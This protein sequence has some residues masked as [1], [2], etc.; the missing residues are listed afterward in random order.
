MTDHFKMTSVAELHQYSSIEYMVGVDVCS[1]RV[2]KIQLFHT[3]NQ[4]STVVVQWQ[5]GL[6]PFM[7][8]CIHM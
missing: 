3:T 8:Q 1:I 2:F 6:L 4:Y 5:Y 7:S